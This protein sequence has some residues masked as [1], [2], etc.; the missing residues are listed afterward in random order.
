MGAYRVEHIIWLAFQDER[1]EASTELRARCLNLYAT[2]ELDH[3]VPLWTESRM[4]CKLSSVL[5]PS[6][7]SQRTSML[8]DV[9]L[10]ITPSIRFK[11]ASRSHRHCVQIGVQV[12]VQCHQASTANGNP[13]SPQKQSILLA[14]G[15]T[16]RYQRVGDLTCISAVDESK[17]VVSTSR[18]H[19]SA[20]LYPIATQ[21][22]NADYPPTRAP[23]P[24]ARVT[25]PTWQLRS[26]PHQRLP[27]FPR[28]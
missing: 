26:Y 5:N 28:R 6:K 10:S 14:L 20:A 2:N 23:T 8:I 22:P 13:P 24:S 11:P 25:E 4:N 3:Y 15:K 9:S 16:A 12:P 27:P 1:I 7:Y 19:V 18:H 17:R 21:P